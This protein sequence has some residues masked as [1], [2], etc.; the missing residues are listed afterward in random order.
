MS[1]LVINQAILNVY[2]VLSGTVA[3][4]ENVL[5]LEDKWIQGYLNSTVRS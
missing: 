1:E 4:S 5:N 2:D 3:P